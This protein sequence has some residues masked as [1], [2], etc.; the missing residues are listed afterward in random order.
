MTPLELLDAPGRPSSDEAARR[1][2]ELAEVHRRRL[3]VV[4]LEL[5]VAVVRPPWWGRS[6]GP[7]A[8]QLSEWASCSAAISWPL[9]ARVA[10]VGQDT[11]PAL[12]AAH[13][14]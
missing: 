14:S 1:A 10:E 13:I 9:A 5:G 12:A 8:S 4:G 2:L 7:T 11:G 3:P 6:A